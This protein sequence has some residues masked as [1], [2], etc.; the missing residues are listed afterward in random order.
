VELHGRV[1]SRFPAPAPHPAG[2]PEHAA[3]ADLRVYPYLHGVAVA[4]TGNLA[5]NLVCSRPVVKGLHHIVACSD[6]G[7]K[8]YEDKHTLLTVVPLG[9]PLPSQEFRK[10]SAA[11][12]HER[13]VPTGT[14]ITV[15]EGDGLWAGAMR[16]MA[17]GLEQ[18]ARNPGTVR[19]VSTLQTAVDRAYPELV[20][21]P[22]RPALMAQLRAWITWQ[23]AAVGADANGVVKASG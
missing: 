11:I 20:Q 14:Y 10:Q 5:V 2:D 15:L 8:G 21:V 17:A 16:M 13:Q 4:T 7:L 1:Q 18:M 22:D 3:F 9:V 19:H 6:D 12:M 23:R